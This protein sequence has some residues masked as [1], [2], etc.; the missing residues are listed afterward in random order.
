M[1]TLFLDKLQLFGCVECS[2]VVKERRFK[3]NLICLPLIGV[4][5]D[6]ENGLVV[7]K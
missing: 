4:E 1:S 6:I 3:V 2:M 5:C 7:C